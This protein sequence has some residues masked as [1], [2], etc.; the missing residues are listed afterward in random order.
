MTSRE[1]VVRELEGAYRQGRQPL[2]EL[3]RSYNDLFAA[4]LDRARAVGQYHISL[5]QLAAARDEL[6]TTVRR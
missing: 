2:V 4:Q 3:I 6:V 5:N 1:K